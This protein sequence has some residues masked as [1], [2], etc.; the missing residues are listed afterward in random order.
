MASRH[1]ETVDFHVKRELVA[2]LMRRFP[3]LVSTN[4]DLIPVHPSMQAMDPVANLA[5]QRFVLVPVEEDLQYYVVLKLDLPPYQKTG[6]IIVPPVLR[7]ERLVVQTGTYLVCG[8]AGE[9]CICY[10]NGQE[11]LGDKEAMMHDGDFIVCW[12]DY[13][14][15][16]SAR[17][18]TVSGLPPLATAEEASISGG[19]CASSSV[20]PATRGSDGDGGNS[21]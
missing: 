12:L 21:S 7:K 18:R 11:L 2:G 8:P 16:K 19:S 3:D 4:F 20:R 9:L 14:V 6:A 1:Y 5:R 13:S 17:G 10:H 15:K